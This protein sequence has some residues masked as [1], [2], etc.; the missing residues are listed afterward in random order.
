MSTVQKI[1]GTGTNLLFVPVSQ[2][3]IMMQTSFDS[4]AT[5]A[6]VT[7]HDKGNDPDVA[8]KWT[9]TSCHNLS[10]WSVGG[11][12]IRPRVV[13]RDWSDKEWHAYQIQYKMQ[14]SGGYR[15]TGPQHNDMHWVPFQHVFCLMPAPQACSRGACQ[16]QLDDLVLQTVTVYNLSMKELS[17]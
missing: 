6:K 3:V 13:I 10:T 8:S 17:N 4:F 7:D 12:N 11:S 15:L 5:I 1:S 9:D 14:R 2:S 16:Y